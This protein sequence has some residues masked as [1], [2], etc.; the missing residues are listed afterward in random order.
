VISEMHQVCRPTMPTGS[1]CDAAETV[2]RARYGSSMSEPGELKRLRLR[3][4][5]KCRECGTELAQGTTALYDRTARQVVCLACSDGVEQTT[6][7]IASPTED[8][9]TASGPASDPPPAAQDEP[10]LDGTV[11]DSGTAGVSARREFERRVSKREQRIRGRHPTL[12]ALIL[13]LSDDPQSTTAWQRGARGEE[14][15]GKRLDGLNE[16]GVRLLH[17]RRI[18]RTRANIDHIVI[19]GAGVFVLDAKRYKGRPHLRIEGGILRP[20]TETLMVGSRKCNPLVD[21][22]TKQVQLV[23]DAVAAG[24]GEV[25]VTGMLVF[26]EADWP[27]FGGDFTTQ[28]VK[29]LWPKKA[30]EHILKPGSLVGDQI[31]ELHRAL[32]NAFPPA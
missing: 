30:T 15:L 10:R 2:G 26:I 8:L 25:P 1:G 21:G 23:T 18:P 13:A 19:S 31:A 22:M 20:R 11:V 24:G 3:Y 29:V 9:S 16:H 7:T 28:G 14:L 4:A 6:L 32:A 27:L 12:G 5:G 17:D